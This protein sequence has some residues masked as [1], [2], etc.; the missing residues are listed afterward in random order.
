MTENLDHNQPSTPFGAMK[1]EFNLQ[2][3]WNK[4]LSDEEADAFWEG[5]W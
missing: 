2:D 1:D 3:D 4:A 5:E